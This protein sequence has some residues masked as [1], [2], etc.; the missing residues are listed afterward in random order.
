[1]VYCPSGCAV[2]C[3]YCSGFVSG[4]WCCV[5][6]VAPIC[7]G[8]ATSRFS[9]SRLPAVKRA[10]PYTSTYERSRASRRKIKWFATAAAV[11]VLLVSPV[12]YAVDEVVQGKDNEFRDSVDLG[13]LAGL[14]D[15]SQFVTD[16]SKFVEVSTPE[17]LL[18]VIPSSSHEL[19]SV[20]SSTGGRYVPVCAAVASEGLVEQLSSQVKAGTKLSFTGS[21]SKLTGLPVCK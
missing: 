9:G 13:V 10:K 7:V 16:P 18:V 15:Q 3:Y 5:L 19:V 21:K 12:K 1:M 11:S 20:F 17:H 14:T 4:L 2:S 6:F 8:M